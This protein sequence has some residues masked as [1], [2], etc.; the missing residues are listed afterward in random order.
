MRRLSGNRHAAY[1]NDLA[2]GTYVV[3]QLPERVLLGVGV[4]DPPERVAALHAAREREPVAERAVEPAPGGERVGALVRGVLMAEEERRHSR[5]AAVPR[6][7]PV[8]GISLNPHA[9][10]AL[11]TSLP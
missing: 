8:S 6:E 11:R 7:P 1:T 5:K 3:G 2:S 10:V 4:D 9:L